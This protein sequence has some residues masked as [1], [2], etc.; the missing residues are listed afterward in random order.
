MLVKA[1]KEFTRSKITPQNGTPEEHNVYTD[2]VTIVFN[3][4]ES[5]KEIQKF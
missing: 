3:I 1:D 2:G 5:Y 4:D